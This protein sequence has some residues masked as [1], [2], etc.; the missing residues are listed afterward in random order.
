MNV[1]HKMGMGI[2]PQSFTEDMTQNQAEFMNWYNLFTWEGKEEGAY[3][4]AI[5]N[6]KDVSCLIICTDWCPDVIWNVPVLFRVMDHGRIRTEVLPME[7]H[8][9]TMDLFLTDGGRAQPIAVFADSNGDVIGKWGARPR[10]IQ[11]VMDEFRRR[12][13]DRSAPDYQENVS[14][15]RKEIAKLYNAGTHYQAVIV[16]ELREL[17]NQF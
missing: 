9:D 4:D 6:R 3:F 5:G 11:T 1:K 12:H 16:Q 8:L 17:F 15:V 2:P 13:P 7:Q 10:Y 14:H